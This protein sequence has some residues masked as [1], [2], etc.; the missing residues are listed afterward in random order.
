M[1]QMYNAMKLI[2]KNLTGYLKNG[3]RYRVSF[4]DEKCTVIKNKRIISVSLHSYNDI[5]D[6]WVLENVVC[7]NYQFKEDYKEALKKAL[8]K[9]ELEFNIDLLKSDLKVAI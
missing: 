1:E 9:S 6:M 5:L 2:T 7:S 8:I 3:N 4:S